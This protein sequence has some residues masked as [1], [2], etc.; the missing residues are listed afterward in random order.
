[1]EKN[2]EVQRLKAIMKKI[3]ENTPREERTSPKESRNKDIVNR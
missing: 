3:T 1:M 2:E